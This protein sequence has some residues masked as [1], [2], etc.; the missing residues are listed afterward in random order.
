MGLIILLSVAS[1]NM[2]ILD[3][4]CDH[5]EVATDEQVEAFMER[6]NE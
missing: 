2:L 3:K 5:C 6:D 4:I 1:Q